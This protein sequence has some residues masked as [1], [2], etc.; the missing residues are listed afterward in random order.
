MLVPQ[1]WKIDVAHKIP[2]E[3]PVHVSSEA[4]EL[5]AVF[6]SSTLLEPPRWW[7]APCLLPLCSLPSVLPKFELLI[8]PPAYIRDL[9]TCETGTVQAR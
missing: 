4:L 5:F 6:T 3:L 7:K 2:R 8:D 1:R 9:D